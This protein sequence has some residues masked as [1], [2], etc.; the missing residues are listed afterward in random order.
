MDRTR[1]PTTNGVQ[2]GVQCPLGL[3]RGVRRKMK[4][5]ITL[6][7]LKVTQDV[8]LSRPG[9]AYPSKPALTTSCQSGDRHEARRRRRRRRRRR[10]CDELHLPKTSSIIL[11]ILPILQPGDI[12]KL[13]GDVLLLVNRRCGLELR[14]SVTT[15]I[16]SGVTMP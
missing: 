1:R 9:G 8:S 11:H 6:I 10:P 16:A 5:R 13:A 2:H 15:M 4:N 7:A 12:H 14:A 3:I